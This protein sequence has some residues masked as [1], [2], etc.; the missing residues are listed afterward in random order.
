MY[1]KTMYKKTMIY[2]VVIAYKF[3]IGGNLLTGYSV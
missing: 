1:K 2:I 3:D